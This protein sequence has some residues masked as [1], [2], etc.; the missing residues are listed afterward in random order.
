MLLP[1]LTSCQVKSL[2]PLS[3][4]SGESCTPQNNTGHA[5]ELNHPPELNGKIP[6]LKHHIFCSWGIK[7]SIHYQST[8]KFFSLPAFHSIGK[9]YAGC[10][11]E[12]GINRLPQLWV[13]IVTGLARHIHRHTSGKTVTGV[14]NYF[15]IGLRPVPQEDMMCSISM[16]KN[17]LMG[18]TGARNELLLLFSYWI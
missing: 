13:T 7:N 17:P 15:M 2:L 11:G 4:S 6:L 9:S 18:S 10:W 3:C 1:A 12:K 5:T 14:C 16:P 8:K